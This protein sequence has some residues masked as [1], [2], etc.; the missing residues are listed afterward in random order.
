MV[1]TYNPTVKANLYNRILIVLGF[2]GLYIAG[3]LSLEK[4]INLELPC[5]TGGGC[6]TVANHPSALWGGIPVAYFGFF[7][8][9]ALAG[10][11][12]LRG[13]QGVRESKG[14]VPVGYAIAAV[15]VVISLYLQ[16]TS[17]FVIKAF[18]PFCMASAITMILT[19]IVYALLSN[20]LSVDEPETKVQGVD[21]I[22]PL[23]LGVV[24]ALT[25][26]GQGAVMKRSVPTVED[27]DSRVNEVE[28]IPADAHSFGDPKAPI[29]V[30]EFADLCCP[31]C[32]RNSPK[33][34]H[35]ITEHPGKI[36]MIYRHFP[37]SM[38]KQ[39]IPAAAISEYAAEKG[40]FWQFAMAIMEPQK[41]PETVDE[42]LSAAT[43]AGLDVAEV[44]NRMGNENDPIYQRIQRDKSVADKLGINSTPTFIVM[45]QGQANKIAKASSI[46]DLLDSDPY[47]KIIQGK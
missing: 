44:A 45:T 15:G 40:K 3:L 23:A 42:L 33:L 1:Q 16:Y 29:T 39:A 22:L 27:A 47:K 9:L 36:R 43:A 35:F 41:E 18:C 28:L 6:Q 21:K 37:L 8:Y 30:V 2:V 17:L 12:A 38:H 46:F 10:L 25:L 5:G 32:Q 34:K 11:A 14:L 7:A 4:L 19:L 24:V 26:A 31:S 13:F 20:S